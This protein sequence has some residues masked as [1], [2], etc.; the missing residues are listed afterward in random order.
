MYAD[1]LPIFTLNRSPQTFTYLGIITQN[2]FP[3]HSS[4]LMDELSFLWWKTKLLYKELD[5][6]NKINKIWKIFSIF[7]LNLPF[8]PIYFLCN[9]L[10]FMDNVVRVRVHFPCSFNWRMLQFSLTLNAY[11]VLFSR[12]RK[13][14]RWSFKDFKEK[15]LK[16]N[17]NFKD[18]APCCFLIQ[19]LGKPNSSFCISFLDFPTYQSVKI[20]WNIK[21]CHILTWRLQLGNLYCFASHKK[22][23]YFI[24]YEA[25]C[26][27]IFGLL[28]IYCLAKLH[29]GFR[30]FNEQSWRLRVY[31]YLYRRTF[32]HFR[33]KKFSLCHSS[34]NLNWTIGPS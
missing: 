21:F 25:W 33:T 19:K 30:G 34:R 2:P 15:R 18:S 5:K 26:C 22:R 10:E 6:Y 8:W 14:L 13:K 12:K 1:P 27:A 3:L 31:L 24:W 23:K 17:Q 20:G 29:L 11:L 32:L 4:K 28:K 16:L 7:F 9:I